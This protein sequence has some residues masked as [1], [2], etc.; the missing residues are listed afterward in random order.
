MSR[1]VL[2]I[3]LFAL[4]GCDGPHAE[5]RAGNAAYRADAFDQAR[6]HYADAL[7]QL[8]TTASRLRADLLFNTAQAHAAD[9]SHQQAV[10]LYDSSRSATPQQD[11]GRR[12][13]AAYNGGLAAYDASDLPG[14]AARFRRALVID[15]DDAQARH[16]WEY[17]ARQMEQD[18]QQGGQNP[19]PEPSDF[20]RRLKEQADAL[21]AQQ[22]YAA[23]YALM[24]DGLAR[25]ETV[26]AFNTF[27][28]RTGAVAQI[29]APTATPR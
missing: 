3:A 17:V 8:D 18:R 24:Q 6:Q 14:S 26:A 21:V 4:T 10:A 11:A 20:A 15:P 13:D 5:G 29:D 22:K 25:D 7:A 12:V 16:N 19:P 23:A 28:A 1:L 2:L 27:I 9:G